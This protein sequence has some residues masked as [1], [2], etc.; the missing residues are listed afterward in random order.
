MAIIRKAVIRIGRRTEA[1]FMD[2]TWE[3]ED[4]LLAHYLNLFYNPWIIKRTAIAVDGAYVG[5][6][7]A[8]MARQAAADLKGRVI[9]VSPDPPPPDEPG[10]E[11]VF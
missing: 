6:P 10:R 4:G 11:I 2:E 9:Y 3:S 7:I 5:D 8:F 1:I